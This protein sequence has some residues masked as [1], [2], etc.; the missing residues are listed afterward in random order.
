MAQ[1]SAGKAS[2][3]PTIDV[4][5]IRRLQRFNASSTSAPRPAP[6]APRDWPRFDSQRPSFLL[7]PYPLSSLSSPSP[8]HPASLSLSCRRRGNASR[9]GGGGGSGAA[10]RDAG[11]HR[12]AMQV[13]GLQ[14][15]LL[16]SLPSPTPKLDLLDGVRRRPPGLA[17]GSPSPDPAS[18]SPDPGWLGP[19]LAAPVWGC[20]RSPMGG[21]RSR[22]GP[23]AG[24]PCPPSPSG[25]SA[26]GGA[27]R[28]GAGGA[29]PHPP[30][31]QLAPLRLRRPIAP[32][33]AA[34][35][36]TGGGRGPK[37]LCPA[38]SRAKASSHAAAVRRSMSSLPRLAC[39]K[40][41]TG[42]IHVQHAPDAGLPAM[43]VRRRCAGLRPAGGAR[44]S[45]T[46]GHV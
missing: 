24:V 30:P 3:H 27:A 21:L 23:L 25:G 13:A 18:L 34:E 40:D 26:S 38:L 46:S 37:P 15:F 5:R 17:T 44:A 28:G 31:A 11:S 20:C 9:N 10:R 22:S 6:S 33:P 8:G 12:V 43:R 2:T 39:T 29:Q 36:R 7:F 35:E 32:R 45:G 1:I 19:D 4:L 16:P 42:C 14:R 41:A